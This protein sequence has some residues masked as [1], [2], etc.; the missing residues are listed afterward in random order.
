MPVAALR[1]ARIESNRTLQALLR[2]RLAC[3]V[4]LLSIRAAAAGRRPP[5][6]SAIFAP[7]RS[8]R[9]S[10]SAFSCFLD[11]DAGALRETSCRDEQLEAG[12]ADGVLGDH[13]RRFGVARAALRVNHLDVGRRAF[14]EGDVGNLDDLACLLCR[15]P[16]VFQRAL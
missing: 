5:A 9:L 13:R 11:C 2:T 12:L 7:L 6:S 14:A 16:G 8:P 4:Q 15:Q 3:N 1:A 10:V